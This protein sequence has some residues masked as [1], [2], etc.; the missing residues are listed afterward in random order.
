MY[1]ELE[2]R[3]KKAKMVSVSE[4]ATINSENYRYKK[5]YCSKCKFFNV[6]TW[7]CNKKRILRICVKENL[8]NME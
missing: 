2:K 3:I 4:Q 5:R 1:Q 7:E 8:R 6:I